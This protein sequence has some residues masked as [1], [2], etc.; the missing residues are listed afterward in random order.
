MKRGL[1]ETDEDTVLDQEDGQGPHSAF[2]FPLNPENPFNDEMF[3]TSMSGV[4]PSGQEASQPAAAAAA[5]VTLGPGSDIESII[6]RVVQAASTQTA[7]EAAKQAVAASNSQWQKA[8]ERAMKETSTSIE[9]SEERLTKRM[10]SM[11]VRMKAVEDKGP[12]SWPSA[13]SGGPGHPGFPA[14]SDRSSTAGSISGKF[15][16][17]RVEIKGWIGDWSRKEEQGLVESEQ[18][19]LVEMVK[20]AVGGDVWIHV[21]E[22][23]TDRSNKYI[24]ATKFVIV[25]K[26]SST[27]ERTWEVKRAM[28]TCIRIGSVTWNTAVLRCV[29]ESPP[30]R[31]VFNTNGGKALGIMGRRGYVNLKP[32]WRPFFNLY[33]EPPSERPQLL[34]TFDGKQWTCNEAN[35]RKLQPPLQAAELLAELQQ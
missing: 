9:A 2:N 32:Q 13:S 20:A 17:R 11:E 21:D 22:V 4:A 31:R 35:L 3:R 18:R 14:G 15:V 12:A 28:D 1:G 6:Q 23:L 5:A 8:F 26:G 10:E 27:S 25:F 30:E 24:V 19:T 29:V 16:P 33:W 34:L 7:G